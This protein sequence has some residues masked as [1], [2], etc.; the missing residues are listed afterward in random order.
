MSYVE[1]SKLLA[2]KGSSTMILGLEENPED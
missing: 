2:S 1:D